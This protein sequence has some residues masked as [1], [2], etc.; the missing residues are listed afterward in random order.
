MDQTLCVP[1]VLARNSSCWYVGCSRYRNEAT[2]KWRHFRRFSRFLAERQQFS[3]Q[4]V[5]NS[6][7]RHHSLTLSS[8]FRQ[9]LRHTTR[10]RYTRSFA[11]STME[12]LLMKA[13]ETITQLCLDKTT[14]Q[15]AALST[16]GCSSYSPIIEL[17]FCCL[18][19][20]TAPTLA[21][22]KP[23]L[24]PWVRRGQECAPWLCKFCIEFYGLT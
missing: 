13:T 7:Q 3:L 12:I 19:I 20:A 18:N 24:V 1:S 8:S 14:S 22:R 23:Q 16:E 21:S 9:L 4:K 2:S 10:Y 15:T 6:M 5:A 11:Q 17:S